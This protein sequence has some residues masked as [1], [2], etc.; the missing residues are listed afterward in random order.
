MT[1]PFDTRDGSF[2]VLVNNDDQ[3]SLWPEFLAVPTGWAV[4]HGPDG[5]QA[6]LDFIDENWTDMRPRSRRELDRC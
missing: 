3:H 2:L 6:C 5:K 4:L 1:N